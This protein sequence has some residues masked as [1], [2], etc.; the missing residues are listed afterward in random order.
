MNG[1]LLMDTDVFLL[2]LRQRD[3]ARELDV[4]Y[5]LATSP[6]RPLVSTVSLGEAL[7]Y[8]TAA[9]WRHRDDNWLLKASKSFV[10][11]D[12]SADVLHEFGHLAALYPELGDNDIWIVA[13]ARV[14]HN[15]DLRRSPCGMDR[16]ARARGI[17]GR[18]RG[19]ASG[20]VTVC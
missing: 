1:P 8:A 2:L 11:V 16:G 20:G 4:R 13:T 10:V 14:C 3:A 12:L 7:A 19:W 17:S 18:A 15:S 6:S 9:G 5:G